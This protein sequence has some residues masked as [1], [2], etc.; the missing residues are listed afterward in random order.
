MKF[1]NDALNLDNVMIQGPSAD[2]ILN[3]MI[4]LKSKQLDLIA[5]ITGKTGATVPLAAALAAS[6]PIIGAAVWLFDR[7]SGAKI[8]H[9]KMQKHKI[10]G[11]WNDP[12]ITNL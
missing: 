2:I 11:D 8:S 7:A 3:G 4:N 1:H 12:K 10:Q 6:N 9:I 5:G